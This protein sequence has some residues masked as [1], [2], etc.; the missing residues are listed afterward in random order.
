MANRTQ[1]LR[2]ALGDVAFLGFCLCGPLVP[3]TFG[4][5]S[6]MYRTKPVVADPSACPVG[7]LV[8]HGRY[9][10]VSA[11]EQLASNSW[12]ITIPLCMILLPT[13]K[14]LVRDRS[15]TTLMERVLGPLTMAALVVLF[16]FGEHVAALLTTGSLILPAAPAP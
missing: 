4:F 10:C 5:F 9:V 6:L 16:F 8:N 12:L 13:A 11:H 2:W 7:H 1:R 14:F 3:L 15:E